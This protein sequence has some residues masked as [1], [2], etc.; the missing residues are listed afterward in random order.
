MATRPPKAVIERSGS[1][2]AV[3]QQ[4]YQKRPSEDGLFLHWCQC[5]MSAIFVAKHSDPNLGNLIANSLTP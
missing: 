1:S 2:H 3:V 4:D 5:K